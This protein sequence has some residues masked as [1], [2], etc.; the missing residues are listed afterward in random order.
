M[1]SDPV[2]HPEHDVDRLAQYFSKR[3][4]SIEKAEAEFDVNSQF[5][6]GAF[7]VALRKWQVQVDDPVRLFE[8]IDIDA[9]F[10][11]SAR[12]LFDV[13]RLKVEQIRQ[14]EQQRQQREVRRIT[15]NLA[16]CI[17]HKFGSLEVMLATISTG[18]SSSLS[19]AQFR[20]LVN[21]LGME[22]DPQQL[23]R[24]FSEIDKDSTDSVSKAEL[25]KSLSYYMVQST[26]VDIATRLAENDCTVIKA[27]ENVGIPYQELPDPSEPHVSEQEL[28]LLLRKLKVTDLV[29]ERTAK[30]MHTSLKPF[31]VQNLIVKL[32]AEW[33]TVA[34]ET[35]SKKQAEERQRQERKH[36]LRHL[37]PMDR[38]SQV[39]K[40]IFS[41]EAHVASNIDEGGITR[42]W[43]AAAR[44]GKSY[45]Q[46]Q[47]YV[48]ALEE[49]RKFRRSHWTRF[50]LRL[51]SCRAL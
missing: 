24:V 19:V 32:H 6:Q 21:T 1:V 26:L 45:T 28:I 17:R 27:F 16:T 46:L 41:W 2:Y 3:Y 7:E 9:N 37:V 47:D 38:Q 22:L 33:Q 39:E 13:L 15:E 18:S 30:L 5:D 31:T 12:E 4:G 40:D 36:R 25:E 49:R 20:K 8:H 44:G 48:A 11:V 50:G 35:E 10:K 42:G 34:Q 29:D 43:S 23:Q 14:R 51:G